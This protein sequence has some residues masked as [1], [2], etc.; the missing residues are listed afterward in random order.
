MQHLSNRRDTANSLGG[1]TITAA[2]ISVGRTL[3]N[4]PDSVFADPDYKHLSFSDVM[5]FVKEYAHLPWTTGRTELGKIDLG[6]RLN[7][8][9]ESVENLYLY[10]Q[11][12]FEHDKA[13]DQDIRD[14]K[15]HIRNQQKAIEMLKQAVAHSS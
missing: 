9:L 5:V 4:V 8:V 14:L 11:Q 15:D 12:L 10:V 7:E 1:G 3:L 2:G 13:Q 6:Q